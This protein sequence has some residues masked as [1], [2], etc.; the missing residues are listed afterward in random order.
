MAAVAV[1]AMV[2][3]VA[4][5]VIGSGNRFSSFWSFDFLEHFLPQVN[6]VPMHFL[7]KKVTNPILVLGIS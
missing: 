7:R 2:T 3:V 6:V 1:M 4:R 5:L